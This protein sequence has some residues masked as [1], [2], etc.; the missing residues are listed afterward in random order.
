MKWFDEW[1]YRKVRW[2]QTRGGIENPEWKHHEDF[3][4]RI[5]NYDDDSEY[6]DRNIKESGLQVIESD[7]HDLLDGL[8]INI[9]KLH[10]GFVV[11]FRHPHDHNAHHIDEVKQNSYI[12]QEDEDFNE[13]LGKLLTMEL[14]K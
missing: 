2:A 3:L 12:I 9:K 6:C 7:S 11:T 14:L 10:G 13:R 4:D 8:R 5:A 1:F